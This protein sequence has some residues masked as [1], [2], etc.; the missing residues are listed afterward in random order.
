M[1]SIKVKDL[2]DRSFH[3]INMASFI[4]DLSEDKLNSLQGGHQ[5]NVVIRIGRN[6]LPGSI[7]ISC[8]VL[9]PIPPLS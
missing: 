1:S 9:L 6:G 4:E 7:K 3:K 5:C 8:P 2:T